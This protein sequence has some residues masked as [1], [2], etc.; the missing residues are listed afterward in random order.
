MKHTDIIRF[1]LAQLH[2]DSLAGIKSRKA[3]RAALNTL[4]EGTDGYDPAYKD[5]MERI[6][7]Q[8]RNSRDIAKQAL[9]WITCAKRLLTTSELQHA[10][11]VELATSELD[12]DNIP[13]IEDIVSVCAG[14]II[15]D[16]ESDII[17][18][19]HYTTEEYFERTWSTWFPDAQ[20]DIA[21]A[22]VTYLSFDT[23]ETGFS[24]TDK[25]FEV[26]LQSNILY[27][28]AAQNWG[29]HARVSSIEGET[30]IL[31]LLESKTKVSACSQAMMV[32][33]S[34]P[35]YSQEVP[36]NITGVHLAAYFGLRRSVTALLNRQ[37]DADLESKGDDGRTPLSWAAENGHEAVVKL[38]LDKDANLESIDGSG[39][40][41]L[42]WA[43]ENGHEEVVKLL[44]D[45]DA[46]LESVDDDG[47]TPLLWA[48]YHGYEAVVKLLLD[49]GAN[50]EPKDDMYGLTPLSWAARKG[51][52]AVVKLLLDKDA[53]VESMDNRHSRTP[54]SWA[55][56]NGHEAVVNLLLKHAAATAVVDTDRPLSVAAVSVIE[57]REAATAALQPGR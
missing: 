55:T 1:L 27:N 37:D 21:K 41:P 42:L 17:R 15:I 13:E 25:D 30:L 32:S 40:T 33:E 3:L 36:R 2:L 10:L 39:R 26:R 46:N 47:R 5:A 14:L 35:D 29:H 57:S 6:E 51:H 38:L 43:A 9:S 34:Y 11:S 52:E 8:A 4:P 22:C 45:K 56:E 54:L 28:Y 20:T 19:V 24:P 7:G 48:A 16:K 12:E 31:G 49:K 18:L 53:D 23:F 44:L 50:L